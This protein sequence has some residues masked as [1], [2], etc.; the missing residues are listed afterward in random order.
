MTNR[1][2]DINFSQFHLD[3]WSPYAYLECSKRYHE[4]K[5]RLGISSL[6]LYLQIFGYDVSKANS[7]IQKTSNFEIQTDQTY[8][9]ERQPPH[10]C[11]M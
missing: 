10:T 3:I 4:T 8:E 6:M 7:R 5:Q 11:Q 9:Q 1:G 2:K